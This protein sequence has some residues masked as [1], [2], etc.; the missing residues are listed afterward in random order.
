MITA[1]STTL[2]SHDG[3]NIHLR[4]WQPEG[5]ARAV[6]LMAHGI[7]EHIGRYEHVGTALAERG[8]LAGGPDHRTH[9]R[10]A[11]EPRVYITDFADVIADLR[12]AAETLTAQQPDV[13]VFAYGHSLGSYIATQYVLAYQRELAGFVSSGS[14]LLVDQQYS[15]LILRAGDLLNRIMPR[16]PFIP[17]DLDAIS[18]DPAV[19]DAYNNDPLVHKDRVRV[20]MAVGFN[21]AVGPLRARIPE[22]TLPLLVLHGGADRTTPPSGSQYLYEHA[23]SADK[24]LK[25]YPGLY[26]EIHNEP[27]KDIVLADILGWIEARTSADPPNADRSAAG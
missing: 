14:P 2:T 23:A 12:L 4:Q 27:E 17:L 5:P 18:R 13:P 21:N 26:H 24:T 1:H 10:S 22:L 16:L 8:Y 19:L 15:P 9:G 11:G 3:L 6:V 25:I 20:R 7:G